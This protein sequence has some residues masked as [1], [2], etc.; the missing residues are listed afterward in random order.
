MERRSETEAMAGLYADFEDR[1]D[2]YVQA[3][4]P[5]PNQVGAV[6]AIHGQV[7]ALIAE[8]RHVYWG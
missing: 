1:I 4:R 2:A 5:V 8:A 3:I 7:F 6:F